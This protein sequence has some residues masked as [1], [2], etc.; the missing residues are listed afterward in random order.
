M[1]R[2]GADRVEDARAGLAVLER[3]RDRLGA[4]L[5]LVVDAVDE[6]R[7]QLLV[8]DD[9]RDDEPDRGERDDDGEKARPKRHGG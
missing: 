6:E 5:R 9:A 8:G 4:A 2:S 3:L 1:A 7:A